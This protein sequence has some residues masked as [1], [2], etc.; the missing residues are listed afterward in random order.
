MMGLFGSI[1]NL[2]S[3]VVNAIMPSK[4]KIQ[5][6]GQ[7]L[8]AA[9]N[10]FSS[11]TVQ[12][13]VKNPV[14]KTALETVANHPYA[15]AG[16]VAGGITAIKT[17]A[18]I[19]TVA[20]AVTPKT[21]KGIVTAA[22]ATP[23]VFGAVL[24]EPTKTIKA[25]VSAP[26]ELAQFGGDIATFA[27][28]PSVSNAKNIIEQSPLISAA[29]GIVAGAGIIKAGSSI[30]GGALQREAIQD[31][32][33]TLEAALTSKPMTSITPISPQTPITPATQPLI[34][35]AGGNTRVS[36]KK[37]SRSQAKPSNINQRIN[38]IVSSRSNSTG[39]KPTKRIINR[40]VLLN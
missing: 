10:P 12:A 36:T 1:A 14:I 33:K 25:A 29:A 2:G 7:V 27:A 34:A 19:P 9:F 31:Q 32:T 8:N 13:N 3:K 38:L 20:K 18:I 39:I 21:P 5:N 16:V 4:E 11:T 30:I 26:S 22:I 40:E 6:V 17:P 35:T 37:R 23:V 15:T 28:N 24:K